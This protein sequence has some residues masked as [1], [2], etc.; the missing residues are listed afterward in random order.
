MVV[1]LQKIS[2]YFETK[3]QK[4]KRSQEQGEWRSG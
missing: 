3:E 1:V 4:M 2:K